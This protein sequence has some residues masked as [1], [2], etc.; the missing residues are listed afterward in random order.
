MLPKKNRITRK[1]FPDFKIRAT[2]AYSQFFSGSLYKNETSSN[3]LS[4]VSVVISKKVAKTAV[5]RNRMRRRFYAIVEPLIKNS[6]QPLS[7]ILY[8]KAESLKVEF[9]ILQANVITTL[10]KAKFF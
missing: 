6:S 8:P 4:H 9:S 1:N 2:R 7:L 10:Q 3:T 5:V